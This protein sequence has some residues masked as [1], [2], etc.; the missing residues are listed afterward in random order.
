MYMDVSRQK[1]LPKILQ[2]TVTNSILSFFATLS[3]QYTYMY[4]S[5]PAVGIGSAGACPSTPLAGSSWAQEAGEESSPGVERL[6]R[7]RPAFRRCAHLLFL[8]MLARASAFQMIIC[9]R[10][11]HSLRISKDYIQWRKQH[12]KLYTKVEDRITGNVY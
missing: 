3:V 10:S 1:H 4:S 5:N 12:K 8:P 9:L 2:R 6:E 7:V 11:F